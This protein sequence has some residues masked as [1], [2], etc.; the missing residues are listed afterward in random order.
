MP[1]RNKYGKPDEY[2]DW[3]PGME[4]EGVSAEPVL[5]NPEKN[6]ADAVRSEGVYEKFSNAGR[7][8]LLKW[9][10]TVWV[11]SGHNS[12][13]RLKAGERNIILGTYDF[14]QIYI[15]R[16]NVLFLNAVRGKVIEAE[17]SHPFVLGECREIEAKCNKIENKI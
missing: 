17:K 16:K 6:R 9:L 10:N 2:I 11:D 12:K 15:E 13:R 7:A 5:E 3:L 4:P 8:E 14:A 1:R